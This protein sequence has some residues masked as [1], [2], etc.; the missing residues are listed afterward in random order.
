MYFLKSHT[1]EMLE[2]AFMSD[3]RS[4]GSHG[5]PYRAE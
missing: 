5:K 4:G 1:P 3:Y 2:L